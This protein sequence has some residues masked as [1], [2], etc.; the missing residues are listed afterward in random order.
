MGNWKK[1]NALSFDGVNDCIYLYNYGSTLNGRTWA[2][3][4]KPGIPTGDDYI[5]F[6]GTSGFAAHHLDFNYGGGA[7][8]FGYKVYDGSDHWIYTDSVS[9]NNWYFVVITR[10]STSRQIYLNGVLNDTDSYSG[11]SSPYDEYVGRHPVSIGYFNG[12]IDMSGSWNRV[13]TPSEIQTLYNNGNGLQYQE[14]EI[15]SKLFCFFDAS[16]NNC[17]GNLDLSGTDLCNY[18][19]GYDSSYGINNANIT[20][21]LVITDVTLTLWHTSCDNENVTFY[22]NGN[23]IH[24]LSDSYDCSCTPSG[25]KWP[26][27]ISLSESE[28]SNFASNWDFEGNNVISINKTYTYNSLYNSLSYAKITYASSPKGLISTTIGDTPFYTNESNPKVISLNENQSQLVTF[29]VNAT[30]A[31]DS[32]HAFF[33]YAN[34]TNESRIS[35]ITNKWGVTIISSACE[36]S[37]SWWDAGWSRRKQISITENSGKYLANYSVKIN[38]DYDS[39]MQADFDDLRFTDSS[40]SELGYWVEEKQNSDYAVVWVLLETLFPNSDSS[41]YMY[42]GN[43]TAAAN[44][45]RE[46]AFLLYSDFSESLDTNIWNNTQQKYVTEK[47][48]IYAVNCQDTGFSWIKYPNYLQLS[49]SATTDTCYERG[50]NSGWL[51]RGIRTN[52]A[53]NFNLTN[54]FIVDLTANIRSFY[55]GTSP[56]HGVEFIYGFA[57]DYSNWFNTKL[58]RRYGGSQE[59]TFVYKRAISDSSYQFTFQNPAIW[60]T[61]EKNFSLTKSGTEYKGNYDGSSTNTNSSEL[62]NSENA[63]FFMAVSGRRSSDNINITVSDV[64]IRTYT[65]PEPV[66]TSCPEESQ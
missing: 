18:G 10:N 24:T 1:G 3:W 26:E 13:L 12:S 58:Y 55:G 15:N 56:D 63:K 38:V 61:G 65:S 36:G 44:S 54:G 51:G 42:Y 23:A 28:L 60:T 5:W 64:Q 8:A 25:Y 57:S 35:N 27:T 49:G 33:A 40:G 4:V 53:V 22:L 45:N 62:F 34:L 30:G 50:Q 47:S 59:N 14:K 19:Y 21:A 31:V 20:N 46:D 9:Y 43:P 11:Y 37:A 16:G 7:N 39:D 17:A 48:S 66:Y 2:F 32:I 29:W 52:E 41:V 6:R